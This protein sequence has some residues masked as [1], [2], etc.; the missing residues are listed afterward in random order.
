MAPPEAAG[1]GPIG[2]QR[3]EIQGIL[4]THRL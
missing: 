3:A 4:D 2:R 1:V